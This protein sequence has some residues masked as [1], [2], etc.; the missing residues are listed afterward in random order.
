MVQVLPFPCLA[1]GTNR[2]TPFPLEPSTTTTGTLPIPTTMEK[3]P[4][5]P[6]CLD[7]SVVPLATTLADVDS[8]SIDLCLH[9]LICA[10][11]KTTI[12]K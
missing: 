5:G 6:Q 3:A 1:V 2:H 8:A 11:C 7:K 9:V 10:L 12:I 4:A